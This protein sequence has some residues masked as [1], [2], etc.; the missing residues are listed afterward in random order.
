[1]GW[2]SIEDMLI[3]IQHCALRS[4][5]TAWRSRCNPHKKKPQHSEA[6]LFAGLEIFFQDLLLLLE[7]AKLLWTIVPSW[8]NSFLFPDLEHWAFWL[9]QRVGEFSID[10]LR[11]SESI[12]RERD[13]EMH[14]G[15]RSRSSS[16]PCPDG[17]V[18]RRD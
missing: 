13:R 3:A 4:E 6:K 10:S 18:M 11:V 8:L 9:P 16:S 17:G 1:V 5:H 12:E 15:M 7:Q 14:V 2:E